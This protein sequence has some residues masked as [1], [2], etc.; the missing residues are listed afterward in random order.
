MVAQEAST[1][2]GRWRRKRERKPE[3]VGAGAVPSAPTIT[4]VFSASQLLTVT[5][6]SPPSGSTVSAT[7]DRSSQ[8]ANLA[9]QVPAG[10]VPSLQQRF[11]RRSLFVGVGTVVVVGG[12]VLAWLAVTQG[13][14]APSRAANDLRTTATPAATATPSPTPTATPSPTPTP[15]SPPQPTPTRQPPRAS[16]V[17]K[18]LSACLV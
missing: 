7:P 14:F 18:L 17:G 8:A 1:E 11:S 15:T 10:A 13:P 5:P 16:S 6:P 9:E 3:R 12:S 2:G 4:P